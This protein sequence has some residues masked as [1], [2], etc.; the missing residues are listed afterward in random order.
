MLSFAVLPHGGDGAVHGQWTSSLIRRC[1]AWAADRSGRLQIRR[2]FRFSR[3]LR[4][5]RETR[6]RGLEMEELGAAL[7]Q[8]RVDP[9]FG[10]LPVALAL[11][12][13]CK[14]PP[15]Y[16][17][18]GTARDSAGIR[19]VD[20]PNLGA[21]LPEADLEIDP[22]WN[23]AEGLEIGDLRDL[24][25]IPDRGFLLL[26]ELAGSISFLSN[27]GEI[28][29][30]IGRDGEGPGEFNPQGLSQVIAT[31]SSVF[32]PDLFLQRLTEFDFAGNVLE[33]GGFPLSPVYAVDWRAHPGGSLAF[34]AIEQFG[35]QII[36]LSGKSVDTI[37]SLQVSNDNVN[38][39]LSPITI[40]ALTE[41]GD[42]AVAR[43]DRAVVE[44]RRSGPEEV[45]WRAQWEQSALDLDEGDVAHLEDL[46]RERVVR[47]A[48]DIT[49][50]ALAATL[51]LIH[52]PEKA[53]VLAGLLVSPSGNIWV[54]RSK[55]VQEMDISVL[56]VGS[57]EAYGGRSWDVLNPEGFWEARVKLPARFTP[58]R[59]SGGWIY[60]ILADELGVET[61]ARVQNGY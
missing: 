19:I 21:S 16:T 12:V 1:I 46:V 5:P 34:R 57:A 26:D 2:R 13:S 43:T 8:M 32:V 35:D 18:V 31:D 7:R 11:L 28:L 41:V 38:L 58:R 20:L 29:A 49:G 44:L 53:P 52:Y 39:L 27:S 33:M 22:T 42:I 9:R 40:W 15:G 45:V 56:Q 59:F 37:L 60:G 54:R 61:V 6:G 51:A 48:P 25:V 36:R 50:E 24:D 23:L 10:L 17:N 47:D 30:L 14:G 3:S 55:S 4:N